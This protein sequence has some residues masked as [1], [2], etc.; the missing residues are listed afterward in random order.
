MTKTTVLMIVQEQKDFLIK[1]IEAI[2]T[3]ASIY[4]RKTE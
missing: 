3:Y 1:S 2:R 4:L